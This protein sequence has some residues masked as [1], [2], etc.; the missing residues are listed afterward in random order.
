M[1]Y[2]HFFELRNNESNYKTPGCQKFIRMFRDNEFQGR[3]ISS[4]T[5]NKDHN[6]ISRICSH[7][8]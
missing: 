5:K 2:Q 4:C 8:Y 1:R 7:L 3:E 6:Y